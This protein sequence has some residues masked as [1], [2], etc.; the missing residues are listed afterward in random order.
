MEKI[1]V[2]KINNVKCLTYLYR[3]KKEW[4]SAHFYF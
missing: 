3:F 2:P 4:V 1:N